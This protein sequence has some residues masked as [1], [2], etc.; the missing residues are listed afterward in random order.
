MTPALDDRIGNDSNLAG[1]A[2]PASVHQAFAASLATTARGLK[3]RPAQ[4]DGF[5]AGLAHQGL[6]TQPAV[7]TA[8]A[9]F[10]KLPP[11]ESRT[12]KRARMAKTINECVAARDCVTQEDLEAAGF[13]AADIAQLFR[14]A[15]RASGVARMVA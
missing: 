3:D 2:T 1:T 8:L 6:L 9:P 7:A 13:S 10:M 15:L 12:N 5:I 14:E 11:P 4:L